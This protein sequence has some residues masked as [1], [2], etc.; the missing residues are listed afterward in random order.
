MKE[1]VLTC[2]WIFFSVMLGAVE[3]VLYHFK[4]KANITAGNE[5]A[6][7]T[8][9]R[10]PAWF[11]FELAMYTPGYYYSLLNG[12]CLVLI[13]VFIHDGAYYA[14]MNQ[15]A[16]CY[17]K[18]FFDMSTTSNSWLDQLGLTRPFLRVTYFIIG[19]TGLIII[20]YVK[21]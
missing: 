19:I 3:A 17:P 10:I 15:L 21:I 11:A 13:F 20:N 18:G 16:G 8:A 9:E 2:A 1:L 7:F 5:H 4:I 12:V 14:R 6:T